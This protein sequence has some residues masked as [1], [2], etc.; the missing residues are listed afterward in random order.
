MPVSSPNAAHN[1]PWNENCRWPRRLLHV[2]S[3]TSHHWQPGNTYGGYSNPEYNALSYTWGRWRLKPGQ[4][5]DVTSL[6]V[7]GIIDKWSIPRIDPAHFSVDDFK[8][9][10]H[11]AANANTDFPVDFVWVDV[12]CIDQ[13][14]SSLEMASEVGRQAR[15]FKGANDVFIWLTKYNFDELYAWA[16]S[17]ERC[18]TTQDGMEEMVRLIDFLRRDPW[19]TSLWTLQEAFLRQDATFL[20][21]DSHVI[22]EKDKNTCT[23]AVRLKDILNFVG[24]LHATISDDKVPGTAVNSAR[25]LTLLEESGFQEMFWGFPMVL[26]TAAKYRQTSAE[27]AADRVYGIMQVFDLQLGSSAPGVSRSRKFVLPELQDQ[28]GAGLLEKY[29]VMSQLHTHSEPAPFGKAWRLGESSIVPGLARLLYHEMTIN[30]KLDSYSK[31]STTT[32]NDVMWGFFEGFSTSVQSIQLAWNGQN[33][34]SIRNASD[35]LY[36]ALDTTDPTEFPALVAAPQYYWSQNQVDLAMHLACSFPKLRVL[37]LAVL[38]EQN[39]TD[40]DQRSKRAF[41]LFLMPKEE[42]YGQQCLWRRVGICLWTVRDS[43]YEEF[44]H[45]RAKKN[46]FKGVHGEEW[47]YMEGPFG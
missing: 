15:I 22:I 21:R 28:L 41:G 18:S 37:L 4:R 8:G 10:I 33:I 46:T 27:R 3:M 14:E 5:P 1:A 17:L 20:S 31:L 34:P 2:S 6:H 30:G 43:D 11:T 24:M 44:K 23:K 39:I 35:E 32:I 13:R 19:F 12:A 16:T 45:S 47:C 38:L 9:A 29:P 40:N 25:L 7:Q 36:I 42:E 26:L